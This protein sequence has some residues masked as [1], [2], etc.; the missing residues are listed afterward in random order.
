MQDKLK[1]IRTK[2]RKLD[3]IAEYLRNIIEI[4][5]SNKNELE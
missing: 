5:K 3:K 4:Q 2:Q 1:D